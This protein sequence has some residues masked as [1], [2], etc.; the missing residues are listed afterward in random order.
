MPSLSGLE[1]KRHI[2]KRALLARVLLLASSDIDQIVP[3]ALEARVRWCLTK[4]NTMDDLVLAVEALRYNSSFCAAKVAPEV[5]AEYLATLKK[6]RR[7][8]NKHVRQLTCRQR[9]VLQL[10]AEGNSSRH[11][12]AALRISTS[13]AETHRANI[14]RKIG[15][16]SAAGLVRYAI[17]NH[18]VQE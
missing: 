15:C 18:M 16:Q 1:A 11:V 4:S 3:H 6:R 17:R 12:G 13:T 10:L 5:L 8:R 2:A 7:G 9:Q 14:M